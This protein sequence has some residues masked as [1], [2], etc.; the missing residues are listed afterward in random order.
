MDEV[1]GEKQL[2]KMVEK[3]KREGYKGIDKKILES[4]CGN[5]LAYAGVFV[6]NLVKKT[7]VEIKNGPETVSKKDMLYLLGLNMLFADLYGQL[8]YLE[9][10]DNSQLVKDRRDLRKIKFRG[11]LTG[12]WRARGTWEYGDLVNQGGR[13]AIS[14][15]HR[16]PRAELGVPQL[17]Y[18]I[19]KTV[20]QY[21]G[22]KDS[23]GKEIYEGDI[24]RCNDGHL[25]TVNWVQ[26]NGSWELQQMPMGNY[27]EPMFFGEFQ[28]G[29]WVVVG[30]IH[31][32]PKM[33]D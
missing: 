7:L 18:V 3:I 25:R 13:L 33:V 1:F 4:L 22:E 19:P 17:S 24:I 26:D 32:N 16:R 15:V 8:K 12:D 31:D 27:V 29:E 30:N 23:T 11:Q 5:E 14:P 20:G 6:G 9:G 21:T 2:L 28:I 10:L